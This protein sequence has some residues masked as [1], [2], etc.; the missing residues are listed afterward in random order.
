MYSK[1]KSLKADKQNII[2]N[3]ALK[4]FAKN[5]FDNASTNEIV[6]E[7]GISKGSLF[8]YFNSKKDL[9]LYLF[10]YTT[11]IVEKMFEEIDISEGDLFKRIG[12]FGIRKLKAHNKNP[13]VFDFLA[14]IKLE[15]SVEVKEIITDK[16]FLISK[17]GLTKIYE[18]I[19][20]SKF[21]GDI[22]VEKASEI[23]NWT[24]TGFGEKAIKEIDKFK[25]STEFGESYLKEW[26]EYSKILKENFYK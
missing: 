26:E 3:A 25:D 24:M 13:Y 15:E 5:G 12:D 10:D 4:E 20:Y 6:K 16:I 2:V 23:L 17:S 1:F 19:D 21:R 7:A 9:Y 18:N 14:S 22:D 11:E 8:N